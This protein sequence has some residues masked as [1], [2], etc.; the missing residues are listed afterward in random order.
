M[1]IGNRAVLR[2]AGVAML[3]IAAATLLIPIRGH[4]PAGTIIGWL[5]LAAGAVEFV[6]ARAR[7]HDEAER[8]S[9]VAAAIT[10]GAGVLFLLRPLIGLYPAGFV[11]M[12]W[13]MLR[14]AVLLRAAIDCKGATR[15]WMGFAG[16]ADL[17]L[18]VSLFV[19]LP[20]AA[21]LITLLRSTH[22]LEMSFA[23]VLAASQL[24]TG[25]ALIAL[26]LRSLAE[27]GDAPMER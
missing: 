4:V 11:I 19:G 12:A 13:L 1:K 2:T 10:V 16:A 25:I 17:L 7:A 15:T 23:A 26:S 18:G 8:A 5:L 22:D 14:G 24:V 27:P 20:I 3:I 6:A 9:E 21:L